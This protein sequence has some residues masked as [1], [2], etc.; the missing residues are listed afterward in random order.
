M[1][2]RT[3]AGARLTLGE[4]LAR[5]GEATVHRI[6]GQSGLVAKLYTRP[7]EGA[8]EKLRHMLVSPPVDPTRSLGHA[9]IAWPRD[10]LLDANGRLVGFTMPLI[11]DAV[12]LLEVFNPRRR[13]Q[14]LPGFD[15]RYLHRTARN[16]ASSLGALHAAAYV[17]GDLNEGNILV[18]PRTLVTLIDV[19][20]FQVE[21][22]RGGMIV[23]HPC[24]V[25]RAEYTAPELQ[26]Q[27]F[28]DTW[29]RPEHDSFGLAVLVFQLLMNGG[30]PYRGQWLGGGEP[31]G[32]EDKI[33]RG[34]FPWSGAS[35]E[36]APPAGAPPLDALHPELVELLLRCF[37]D[38]QQRPALRPG[39]EAWAEA[40]GVAEGHLV[41]CP[42]GHW[43]SDH[44]RRCPECG[45]RGRGGVA[46]AKGR[47]SAVVRRQPAAPPAALAVGTGFLRGLAALGSMPGRILTG[48]FRALAGALG[49]AASSPRAW[50]GSL[51][52]TA[53][54]ALLSLA[55]AFGLASLAAAAHGALLA[56]LDPQ[57]GAGA[58][59]PATLWALTAG[60]LGAGLGAGLRRVGR[61]PGEA[62]GWSEFGAFAESAAAA[63]GGWLGGWSAA[64]LLWMLATGAPWPASLLGSAAV[65][66]GNASPAWILAWAV[67]GGAVAAIGPGHD[68]AQPPRAPL[69]WGA[70]AAVFAALGWVAARMG[71]AW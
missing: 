54:L 61:R 27:A 33:A 23:I 28:A 25:G 66:G 69:G 56:W 18:T 24:P 41:A 11:T 7:R 63:L 19:D 34:L 65:L 9:S 1:I 13:A 20:S 35:A 62:L 53:G 14:V 3:G 17:V 45:G 36:L 40:L 43:F 31:P 55:A 59:A 47:P 51:R 48:G 26:G 6:Q 29:R 37:V 8:A 57:A 5:G 50:A 39:A 71:G 46:I 38:G 52:W 49:L 30:H 15:R 22:R 60:G 44:L 64:A 68:A 70:V 58:G 10:L 42:N 67:Y 12:S 4:P 16:L 2:V 32:I 21:E